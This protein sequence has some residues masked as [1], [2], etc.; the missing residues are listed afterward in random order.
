MSEEQP[1]NESMPVNQE[2]QEVLPPEAQL[3]AA[4]ERVA[5]GTASAEDQAL[6]QG[7]NIV[8]ASMAETPASSEPRPVEDR[9]I[10]N[11][12]YGP[13]TRQIPVLEDNVATAAFGGDQASAQQELKTA[14]DMKTYLESRDFTDANG[15]LHDAETGAFKSMND[16]N[17][18][19]ESQTQT[20]ES[21][22]VMK[23]G[24]LLDKWA[25]AMDHNDKTTSINIQDELYR[26]ILAEPNLS[27]DRKEQILQ[28]YQTMAEGRRNNASDNPADFANDA[29]PTEPTPTEAEPTPPTEVEPTNPDAEEYE[30]KEPD[31]A[32]YDYVPPTTEDSPTGEEPTPPTEVEPTPPTEVEP[33]TPEDTGESP[34]DTGEAEETSERDKSLDELREDIDK[35]RQSIEGLLA[36]LDRIQQELDRLRNGETD[37][38]GPEEEEEE[39][40]VEPTEEMA[41]T[42]EAAAGEARFAYYDAISDYAKAKI[43]AEGM[44]AG[45]E[46]KAAFETAGEALKEAREKWLNAEADSIRSADEKGENL[47]FINNQERTE[48]QGILDTLLQRKEEAGDDYDGGLEAS[49]A[50]QQATL[51]QLDSYDALIAEHIA[52]RE[53]GIQEFAVRELTELNK[54]V[55][56]EMLAERTRRH[57][58]LAKINNWLQKH[59]KTRI[60]VGLGLT[61]AGIVG[62]ATFNAPLVAFATGAKMGLSG[63]GSYNA[64]RGIG[65]MIASKR[66]N[67]T[68]LATIDDYLGASDK[69]STTRRR[70]KRFATAVSVAL[71]AA[72][73]IIA[74]SEAHHATSVVHSPKPPQI[75]DKPPTETLTVTPQGGNEYPWTYAMN[76]L[77]TNIS[78]QASMDQW[79]HNPYGI[80]FTSNGLGG[81]QGAIT[82][83]FIP[84][85][86]TFTDNAHINGAIAAILGKK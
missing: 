10:V 8:A 80:K 31:A 41:R 84:G 28:S 33:T 35:L 13:V 61:A 77:G 40:E 58:K 26:R 67:K 4:N 83:V 23:D 46:K 15:K 75:I 30:F 3:Q 72:P 44:F 69:Q 82:S 12:L 51:A 27:D 65:E 25:E 9:V 43:A 54:R 63:Y 29:A 42:P 50:L 19:P 70:S 78:S 2:S 36:E 57:P 22:D 49:I 79:V 55:D 48:A 45:A 24:G 21:M 6:V 34:E 68:E 56:D 20:Y 11:D 73:A 85:Q 64:S 47:Q 16:A 17:T 5:N 18:R 62:A 76:H 39:E 71:A 59:P 66:M 53:A 74:M 86:G 7:A 32:G 52:S 38:S 81:G 1:T 37:E 60:G 14:Q